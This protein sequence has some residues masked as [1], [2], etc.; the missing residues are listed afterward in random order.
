[1]EHMLATCFGNRYTVLA[2]MVTDIIISLGYPSQ[3][4]SKYFS[5]VHWRYKIHRHVNHGKFVFWN[6]LDSMHIIEFNTIFSIK[7]L[8]ENYV[9]IIAF[10]FLYD[11]ALSALLLLYI[12]GMI[13][14]LNINNKMMLILSK[15]FY[16]QNMI[17]NTRSMI[18]LLYL[19][20][21]FCRSVFC[22]S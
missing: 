13:I 6:K 12:L 11:P 14:F 21:I 15:H 3:K 2:N 19:Y 4:S 22:G 8:K 9:F 18:F 5:K 17:R 20:F 16:I 10:I 7:T 1:M